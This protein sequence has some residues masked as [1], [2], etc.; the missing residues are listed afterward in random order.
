MKKLVVHLIA[1]NCMLAGPLTLEATGPVTVKENGLVLTLRNDSLERTIQVSD[2]LV[3]T[4]RLWNKLSGRAY[5]IGGD[6]F[7]L[8]LIYERIGYTFGSENP[9]ILTTRDFAVQGH[10]VEDTPAGGKRVVF[11]LELRRSPQDKTGIQATLVYELQPADFYTRQ[12]IEL[13]TTGIGT[14]FVDS[15]ALGRNDWPG[16]QFTLGGFGQPLFSRDLFLGYEYPSS[17]NVAQGSEIRLARVV[18]LDIPPAGFTSEPAVIGVAAEGTVHPAFLEYVRKIRAAPVRPFLAYN[19]WYDLQRRAMNHDNTRERA[20]QL[21]EKLLKKY[22]LHL[23]S[24]VLD[25]GWDD[26]GNLWVIEPQRFPEGFRDLVS[27]LEGIGSRLGLWFGPIGGYDQREVR[28]ATGR[29]QGMEITSNG[30]FLCLA[31]HN[32]SRLFHDTLLRYVNEYAVNFYKLDGVPFGC[33]EPDHGHPMGIYSREADLRVFIQLL[34]DLRRENPHIFLDATTSIW[35][36]PWWLRYAD[37]VW[38]GGEDYGYLDTLPAL[39]QRQSSM[40]Y[41][42]EVLYDDYRTHR[43]QFPMS[44][45]TTE[46]IIKGTFLKLGG[47]HESLDDWQDHVISFLGVGSQLYELYITPSLLTPPEWDALGGMLKWA[48]ANAHPLLDNSTFVL[49][50]P[51]RR[52]PYGFLHYSPEKTL[53]MLRNPFVSPA[54]AHLKLDDEA[55]FVPG[56]RAYTAEVIYPYREALPGRLSY[57]KTVEIDLDGYEHRLIELCPEGGR[58]ARL[59]GI[60]YSPEPATSAEARFR[61]Y[62]PAGVDASFRVGPPASISEAHVDGEKLELKGTRDEAGLTVHFGNSSQRESQPTFSL[63]G[64]QTRTTPEALRTVRVSLTVQTPADFRETKAALLVEPAQPAKVSAEARDNG[65]SVTL[66]TSTSDHNLWSWFIADLTPGSHALEFTL[67]F[68]AEA[69]GEI[70]LSGWLRAKRALAGRELRLTM[71]PG[72]RAPTQPES[73]LPVTSE[74]QRVTY[75]LFERFVR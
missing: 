15:L 43:V 18:G 74:F 46:S 75:P 40:N 72:E 49:G 19:S 34:E 21:R 68:P 63:P 7:E 70:K 59:E 31:G 29:R 58:E 73:S 66:T 13:K 2:G 6:E 11:R 25:D 28:I 48:L 32:Y 12:W 30:E 57:G 17:L 65:K 60:R 54:R 8:K 1:I 35:L 4:T 3:R 14:F 36:S 44:S 23:D 10:T 52:E 41:S 45:L 50:D 39:T 16:A 20:V 27:S 24:F 37:A 38:M 62:A 26:M 67:Q 47:E 56:D 61:I 51:A 42:D 22:D 5:E 33:N 55:G 71:K 64:I 53:I 9:L 69:T